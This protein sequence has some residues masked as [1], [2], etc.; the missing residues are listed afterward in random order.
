MATIPSITAWAGRIPDLFKQWH[1]VAEPD[2]DAP[3]WWAGAPS[4]ARDSKGI[5]WM[6]V[7]MR[8]AEG[9]L[10]QRGYEIRI[11]RSDDGIHFVQVHALKE[12][13]Y[14]LQVLNAPR[15]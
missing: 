4:V 14:P 2:R 7:R 12:N 10:G 8:T 1:V 11:F 15:S 5:F 3:E 9:Q 13:R 6:A